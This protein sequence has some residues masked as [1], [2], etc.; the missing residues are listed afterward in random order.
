MI[1]DIL[2][3]QTGPFGTEGSAKY[4]VDANESG[5]GTGSG[6]TPAFRS[7]EPV[8]K[9]LGNGADA[10]F[11]HT[12]AA[13]GTGS[14]AKPVVATDFMVG[15]TSSGQGGLCST[16]TDTADGFV[17]VTPLNP[18]TIYLGIPDVAATWNTQALYDALV[19]SRVLMKMSASTTNPAFTILASDSSTSGLVIEELDITKYPGRVAFSLRNSLSYAD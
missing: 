18:G 15:I 4:I 12:L 7:G 3:L 19:G 17:Y 14:S 1:N 16:E 11:V 8:F 6:Y 13:I 2:I 9:T 5:Q 10:N